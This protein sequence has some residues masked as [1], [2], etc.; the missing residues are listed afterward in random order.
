M[1]RVSLPSNFQTC[2]S[3]GAMLDRRILYNPGDQL[4]YEVYLAPVDGIATLHWKPYPM[5]M[6][7]IDGVPDLEFVPAGVEDGLFDTWVGRDNI[8]YDLRVQTV[9]GVQTID[10]EKV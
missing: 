9:D 4:N 1:F 2:N 7:V 5:Q 6:T 10:W 3:A 8:L